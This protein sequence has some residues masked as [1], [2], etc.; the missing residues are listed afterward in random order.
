[1]TC[2]TY[3]LLPVEVAFH[4]DI[5]HACPTVQILKQSET[6]VGKHMCTFVFVH[7][8]YSIIPTFL[9]LLHIL[10]PEICPYDCQYI[11]VHI[12]KNIDFSFMLHYIDIYFTDPFRVS[13]ITA[14]I[15]AM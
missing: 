6:W 14:N 3:D 11:I 9:V 4:T 15:V 1:M 10:Y 2:Y 13:G 12:F 7:I 8:L 5:S